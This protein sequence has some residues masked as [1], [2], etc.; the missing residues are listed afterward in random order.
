MVMVG[1]AHPTATKPVADDPK[2]TR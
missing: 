1:D 2:K